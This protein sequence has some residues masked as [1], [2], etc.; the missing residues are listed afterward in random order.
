MVVLNS[1]QIIIM[2]NIVVYK[3]EVPNL[4]HKQVNELRFEGRIVESESNQGCQ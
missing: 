1:S 3:K 2:N 4:N